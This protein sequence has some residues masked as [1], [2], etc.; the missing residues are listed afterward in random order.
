MDLASVQG[1]AR[2]SCKMIT[3]VT[4]SPPSALLSGDSLRLVSL[5]RSRAFLGVVLVWE[6]VYFSVFLSVSA[7]VTLSAAE[8]LKTAPEKSE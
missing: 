2:S 6:F 3:D 8:K 4:G 1:R 7:E 5:S